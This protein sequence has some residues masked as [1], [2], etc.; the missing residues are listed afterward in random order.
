M[1]SNVRN[2]RLQPILELSHGAPTIIAYEILTNLHNK[3]DVEFFFTGLP[4]IEFKK[5]FVFQVSLCSRLDGYFHINTPLELL[6]QSY[7]SR[8]INKYNFS[9]IQPGKLRIELQNPNQLLALSASDLAKIRTEILLL[10]ARGAEVWLDD[11]SESLST[12]AIYLGVDGV[13]LDKSFFWSVDDLLSVQEKFQKENILVIVEGVET[14]C[15][16]NKVAKSDCILV[17][18]FFWPDVHIDFNGRVSQ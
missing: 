11:I 14:I 10:Q 13:K 12:L 4:L 16:Y 6:L 5:L 1:L 2:F 18:G 3:T 8:V 17:Q 9:N 15:H 7:I